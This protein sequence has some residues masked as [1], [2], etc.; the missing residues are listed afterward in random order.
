MDLEIHFPLEK[1]FPGI[2][3]VSFTFER[4]CIGSKH[5]SWNYQQLES[6]S[7]QKYVHGRKEVGAGRQ[8]QVDRKHLREITTVLVLFL[9]SFRKPNF[10]RPW[11]LMYMCVHICV[12]VSLCFVVC[13]VSVCVC[14]SVLIWQPRLLWNLNADEIQDRDCSKLRKIE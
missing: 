9:N 12:C 14:F 6:S 4:L 11:F 1:N 7:L 3:S 5:L 13:G 10:L 2:E 8:E